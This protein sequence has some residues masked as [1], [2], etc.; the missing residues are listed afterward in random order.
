MSILVSV[1]CVSRWCLFLWWRVSGSGQSL[2]YRTWR[3]ILRTA[4]STITLT[5]HHGPVFYP[6]P[7]GVCSR[8]QCSAVL[9]GCRIIRLK[10]ISRIWRI[11]LYRETIPGWNNYYGYGK[12]Q[13][14]KTRVMYRRFVPAKL[15]FFVCVVVEFCHSSDFLVKQI[16]ISSIFLM[17]EVTCIVIPFSFVFIWSHVR[18]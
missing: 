4:R 13:N 5:Q 3:N 18:L 2:V 12:N 17:Q 14:N 8:I 9:Y 7:T 1:A 6:A 11:T 15:I 16:N 10:N